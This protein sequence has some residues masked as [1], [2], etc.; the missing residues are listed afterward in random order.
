MADFDIANATP[1]GQPAPA[2]ATGGFDLQNATQMGTTPL[3]MA[4]QKP[5]EEPSFSDK[6]MSAMGDLRRKYE[7]SFLAGANQTAGDIANKYFLR[8][9][10]L[11]GRN[12]VQG[13]ANIAAAPG[14]AIAAVERAAGMTPENAPYVTIPG[15]NMR[16]SPWTG[17]GGE[18]VGAAL[19]KVLPHNENLGEKVAGGAEQFLTGF[20]NNPYGLIKDV[21]QGAMGTVGDVKKALDILKNRLSNDRTSWDVASRE[22]QQAN[23]AGIPLRLSN[24]GNST[25]RT[26]E[27]TANKP[28]A[29][30][31]IIR[32]DIENTQADT[33]MRVPAM[34]REQ[35]GAQGDVGTTSDLLSATRS[36]NAKVNY[37]AV[38]ADQTPVR[39]EQ[40]QKVLQ[41]PQVAAL[42]K[43][44]ME[45]YKALTGKDP[46]NTFST[47]WNPSTPDVASLDFLQRAMSA[48]T[49]Q[50]YEEATSPTSVQNPLAGEFAKNLQ[51]SR[52]VLVD[53]LKE[54]SPS[55]KKAYETYG[56][57]SEVMEA[58]ERGRS[59]GTEGFFNMSP[60][61]AKQYVSGL[62]E[63][64]LA[65]LRMGVADRMLKSGEMTGRGNIAGQV[66]G[67]PRKQQMIETL[68]DGDQSKFDT[69]MQA[70]RWEDKIARS[71][72]QITGGS[73]TYGRFAAEEGFVNE[74]PEKLARAAAIGNQW[75]HRWKGAA[76]HGVVRLIGPMWNQSL[77]SKTASLLQSK[78][79]Q[80]TLDG[81]QALED[82]QAARGMP[83]TVNAISRVGQGVITAGGLEQQRLE[84]KYG[85]QP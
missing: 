23:E 35:M 51:S 82:A 14:D 77:A 43:T 68:F 52:S 71:N 3:A 6:L 54:T 67:G 11:V 70:L 12:L 36:K 81:M 18:Q 1:V 64:G 10:Q 42:Y 34:V 65:A 66:M 58:M 13:A 75:M 50:L 33:S 4:P 62:S 48:R 80:V 61:Q 41:D 25:Q 72:Q 53:R 2:A 28:G 8:P 45:N 83:R 40:I 20:A 24:M 59:Q 63:S 39:D 57:D 49:K 22:V 32:G 9:A 79:P 69:F 15:I 55:F 29:A 21:G 76:I 47:E 78:N 5:P 7:P 26:A 27:V 84:D 60:A 85:A 30:E 38:K 44:V 19:N 37:A 16:L 73:Q 31:G 46:P 17:G 56:D 74:M